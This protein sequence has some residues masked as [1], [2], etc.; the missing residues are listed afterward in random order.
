MDEREMRSE[1]LAGTKSQRTWTI[2]LGSLNFTEFCIVR[3]RLWE[4][5]AGR[6][7]PGKKWGGPEPRRREQRW[8]HGIELDMRERDIWA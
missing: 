2:M 3:D 7:A 8:R 6:L 4:T 5:K 1:V